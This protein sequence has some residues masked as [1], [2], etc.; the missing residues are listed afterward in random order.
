MAD[1][2]GRH[3]RAAA[4]RIAVPVASLA[5][6]AVVLLLPLPWLRDSAYLGDASFHAG[7]ELVGG[8]VGLMAGIAITVRYSALAE[9]TDLLIGLA[10]FANGTA[11]VVHGTLALVAARG[12]PA[13]LS[14]EL[15]IA[16]TS[17]TGRFMM[18]MLLLGAPVFA[19]RMWAQDRP[20]RLRTV[21]AAACA[22]IA[23][24]AAL[25]A[26]AAQLTTLPRLVLPENL[27]A[28]PADFFSGAV[29]GVAAL[30]LLRHHIRTGDR[31]M[32]WVTIAAAIAAA[33]QVI[34]GFS[35]QLYDAAFDVAHAYKILGY[36][37]PLV[38]LSLYH[39]G[40]IAERDRYAAAVR[41]YTRELERA[42]E[43]LEVASDA[44]SSFVSVVSHELRTPLTSILGFASMMR[45]YWDSTPDAEKTQYLEVI[46]RQADRLSRLVNDLLAISRLESGV[47]EVRRRD[48]EVAPLLKQTL[49]DLG[50]VAASVSV[51]VDDDLTVHADPDHLE[52]ILVNL[53]GN[54]SKYGEPPITVE[55]YWADGAVQITVAD[56]GPGVSSSFEPK[57]FEKFAQ[58]ESGY[59]RS[60]HGTGLGLAITRGL[61]TVQGGDIWYEQNEPHG[62][63]FCVRLPEGGADA[64]PGR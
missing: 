36:A 5:L 63:R 18:A 17:V 3:D 29:L 20:E 16:G 27:I 62:A 1:Q 40:V 41:R 22:A 52:R 26:F 35:T 24:S 25:T 10:F 12:W 55:A 19:G 34:M 43:E 51:N 2:P 48:I 31:M 50:D 33:G 32:W 53:V 46:E 7:L 58:A 61:V 47:I 23:M 14:L 8:V 49:S 54:A 45:E 9:R 15:L 44:K 4:R 39:V 30:V 6:L 59:T 57:L 64:V 60:S 11:D 37:V 38:A 56:H 21:I 28:R 42:N 13:G